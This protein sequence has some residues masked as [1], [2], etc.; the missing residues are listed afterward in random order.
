MEGNVR[1]KIIKEHLQDPAY[2]D[3]MSK[4]LKEIVKERKIYAI[5]YEEYLKKIVELAK[6][7]INP[8]QDNLSPR[9][10]TNAQRVL[11]NNLGKDETKAI[12]ID[13]AIRKNIRADFR[14]NTPAENEIKRA[15]YE[16]LQDAEETEK[17]FNV[18]QQQNEY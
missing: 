1:S 4:L 12:A 17:I 13:A 16:V 15:I 3:E 7:V 6:R 2:F 9:I 10:Q 5:N 18:I 14:G 8:N 11:Y